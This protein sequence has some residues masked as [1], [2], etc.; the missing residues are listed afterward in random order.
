MVNYMK[1]VAVVVRDIQVGRFR[2]IRIYFK[3]YDFFSGS[4]SSVETSCNLPKKCIHYYACMWAISSDNKFY[5]EFSHFIQKE[6]SF[7]KS[8]LRNNVSERLIH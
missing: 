3:I 2:L 1:N 4:D 5:N 6:I 7:G 8:W